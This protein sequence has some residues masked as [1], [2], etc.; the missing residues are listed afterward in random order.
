V[1]VS[2]AE[3]RARRRAEQAIRCEAQRR[4]ALTGADRI[5]RLLDGENI[6]A[7]IGPALTH[8]TAD[9]DG[10][11]DLIIRLDAGSGRAAALIKTVATQASHRLSPKAKP[12]QF[13]S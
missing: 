1:F 2:P 12:A 5:Q 10:Q 9:R 13:R 7:D 3:R 11:G 4:P 8:G 6:I